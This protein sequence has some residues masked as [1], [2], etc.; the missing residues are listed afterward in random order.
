MKKI[1]LFCI[2]YVVVYWLSYKII[3]RFPATIPFFVVATMLMFIGI[4]VFLGGIF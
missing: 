3:N 2:T 1:A 4:G